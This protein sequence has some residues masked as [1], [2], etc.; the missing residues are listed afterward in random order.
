[1]KKD[2]SLQIQ[3]DIDRIAHSLLIV[4][5]AIEIALVVL[6][7][8]INF[9]EYSSL[10]EIQRLCNIAR[11]DSLASWIGSMQTFMIGMTLC[12]IVFLTRQAS[13]SWKITTGWLLLSLFFI[14]MA[15]DD[16]TEI[17]ERLGSAFEMIFKSPDNSN[18][19]MSGISSLLEFFPSYAWQLLFIPFFAGAGLFI[20]IFLMNE[21]KTRQSKIFAILALSC[22]VFAVGLD[23]FEGL[24]KNHQWNFH[25]Y[26]QKEYQ[27]EKYTVRHFSKSLE[28]FI[29]MLGMTFFWVS[30][31]QYFKSFPK[32]IIINII[33][34][35]RPSM[36]SA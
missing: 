3:I 4:C 24:D 1:M 6:D 31:I 5:I 29:E 34:P 35:A 20:L 15:I 11:E 26:L 33:F 13:I 14:Y 19:P 12:L 21:L 9:Y 30:F 8:F 16:G 7:V 25:T 32:S 18:V 27:L 2:N 17:H 36:P 28:E 10:K 22:F 23:F